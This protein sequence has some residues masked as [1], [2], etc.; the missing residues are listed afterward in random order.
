YARTRS[1]HHKENHVK[2]KHWMRVL[3]GL[4]LKS[5]SMYCDKRDNQVTEQ[6]HLFIRPRLCEVFCY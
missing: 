6:T 1:K 2:T 4:I 3:N 5:L